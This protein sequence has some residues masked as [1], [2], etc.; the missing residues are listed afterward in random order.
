MENDKLSQLWKSQNKDFT[1]DNPDMIIKKAKKQ[2]NGQF[3][4]ITILAT[5][6]IILI[7]FTVK[8]ANTDW[9]NFTLGLTLMI[10]SLVFRLILEFATIYRRE[11]R[12]V[13]LDNQLYQE[14]LKKHY[15]IR[16][17]INYL[18]TPICFGIY[19]YGFTMLLPYFKNEFSEGFYTYIL[20]SGYASFVVIA[21]IILNSI[22]KEHRFLKQ[23]KSK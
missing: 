20:I 23:L 19:I 11:N 4:T 14:Y 17:G 5:T 15:R 12:L 1:L 21:L 7:I 10:S 13:S 2:R 18:I 22:F 8:Y 9:N 16:L 6:I 3:I